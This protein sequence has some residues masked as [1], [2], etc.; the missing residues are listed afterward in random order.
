MLL[1]YIRYLLHPSTMFQ[2]RIN[3]SNISE[4]QIC[5]IKTVGNYQRHWKERDPAVYCYI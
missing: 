1:L 3:P 2:A 5:C 4:I